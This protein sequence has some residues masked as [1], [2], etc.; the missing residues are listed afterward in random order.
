MAAAGLGR[1]Q[2]GYRLDQRQHPLGLRGVAQQGAAV[3]DQQHYDRGL[4]CFVGLLPLPRSCG[5]GTA[6]GVGHHGAQALPVD[7]FAGLEG[8]EQV[9]RGREQPPC[10]PA[11]RRLDADHGAGLRGRVERAEEVGCR[12]GYCLHGGVCLAGDPRMCGNGLC[13]VQPCADVSIRCTAVA[14]RSCLGRFGGCKCAVSVIRARAEGGWPAR[15]PAGDPRVR[16]RGIFSGFEK[17]G[18][19]RARGRGRLRRSSVRGVAGVIRPRTEGGTGGRL[20]S[21]RVIRARGAR[22]R[23]SATCA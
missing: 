14:A 4:G 1:F 16:G 13:C 6:E 10:G 2:R 9:H 19:I 11:S 5:V 21:R 17:P 20:P 22:G 18:V 12:G 8:R 3:A 23:G 15:T 7:L